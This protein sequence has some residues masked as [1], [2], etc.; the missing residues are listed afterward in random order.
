ME[1]LSGQN[2]VKARLKPLAESSQFSQLQP[3]H[4]QTFKEGL[5]RFG[6]RNSAK[7]RLMFSIKYLRER[8]AEHVGEYL[9]QKISFAAL[10]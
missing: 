8:L 4:H 10:H 6:R 9:E 3:R 7:E 5:G 1:T 2:F